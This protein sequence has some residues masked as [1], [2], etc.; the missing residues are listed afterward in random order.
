ML[1]GEINRLTHQVNCLKSKAVTTN[2][3][4]K[5]K[6]DFK[7]AVIAGKHHKLTDS[8]HCTYG[9]DKQC[10]SFF[11]DE[12]QNRDFFAEQVTTTLASS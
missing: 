11:H 9:R 4:K 1:T 3:C 7:N 5:Q 2:M 12:F 8:D 10:K 6:Q